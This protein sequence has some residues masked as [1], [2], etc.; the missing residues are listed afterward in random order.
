MLYFGFIFD[1]AFATIAIINKRGQKTIDIII[2]VVV[3]I[4]DRDEDVVIKKR[5]REHMPRAVHKSAKIADY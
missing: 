4:R 5:E 3:F 1:A 2:F